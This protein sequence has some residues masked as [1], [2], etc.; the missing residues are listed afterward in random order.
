MVN[1]CQFLKHGFLDGFFHFIGLGMVFESVMWWVADAKETQIR[2]LWITD[3]KKKETILESAPFLMLLTYNIIVLEMYSVE[4]IISI[5]ISYVSVIFSVA[6]LKFDLLKEE[7]KIKLGLYVNASYKDCARLM[8]FYTVDTCG[9]IIPLAFFLKSFSSIV[10][11][12]I[13]CGSFL[14]VHITLTVIIYWEHTFQRK[15]R[16]V[17][18]LLFSCVRLGPYVNF[19]MIV[20]HTFSA[21]I[22]VLVY[23]RK[24]IKCRALVVGLGMWLFIILLTLWRQCNSISADTGIADSFRNSLRKFTSTNLDRNV[25][26]EYKTGVI[27]EELKTDTSDLTSNQSSDSLNEQFDS[28]EIEIDIGCKG[29]TLGTEKKR[30]LMFFQTSAKLY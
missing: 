17:L 7:R 23:T 15:V 2:E 13:F 16:F 4:S 9:R 1:G 30:V 21:V 19:E 28:E 8:T 10:T 29:Y 11:R 22:V 6:T 27:S 20:R 18:L 25:I 14:I 3:T 24:T 12:S 26:E 5:I